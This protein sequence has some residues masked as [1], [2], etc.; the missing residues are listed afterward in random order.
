M[1]YE[2]KRLVTYR[3]THKKFVNYCY[4]VIDNS[5]NDAVLIDPAW[6]IETIVES[7]RKEQVNLKKILVTHHHFDHINL[8]QSLSEKYAVN[9]I[10]SQQEV[11]YYQL[12]LPNIETFSQ[13]SFLQAGSLYIDAIPTPG[14]TFGSTCFHIES[15]LFTGDTLFNEGCGLCIGKGADP[16]QMFTSLQKLKK[17]ISPETK[18]YPGHKYSSELGQTFDSVQQYNIY[19]ALEKENDFVQYRMRGMNASMFEFI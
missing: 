10:I 3:V 11:N 8:A 16:K 9:I 4:M 2:N 6:E 7:I 1:Y 15:M 14:H 12:T 5:T 18:I 19:L 17:I 13:R